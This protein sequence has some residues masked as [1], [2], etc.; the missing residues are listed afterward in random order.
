MPIQPPPVCNPDGIAWFLRHC[1]GVVHGPFPF[2]SLTEAARLGRITS[3]TMVSH[4]DFTNSA[5]VRALEIPEIAAAAVVSSPLPSATG[6]MQAAAAKG[7]LFSRCR[8][9]HPGMKILLLATLIWVGGLPLAYAYGV[10][11]AYHGSEYQAGSERY[12]FHS[13]VIEKHEMPSREWQFSGRNLAL[14]TML[15]GVVAVVGIVVTFT[16]PA[17]RWR[18]DA[19]MA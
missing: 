19:T 15:Y 6:S 5:W 11:Q 7:S 1:D 2:G 17:R 16:V 3:D 13:F 4:P 8:P 14:W 9:D 10:A 12:E 18:P